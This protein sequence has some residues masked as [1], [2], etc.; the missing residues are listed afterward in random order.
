MVE[1]R[2]VLRHLGH[3][4]GKQFRIGEV[5][6]RNHRVEFVGRLAGVGVDPRLA[7]DVHFALQRVEGVLEVCDPAPAPARV[8]QR[9]HAV[10]ATVEQIELVRDLVHHDL[11]ARFR[12]LGSLDAVFQR[13]DHRPLFPAFARQF[14]IPLVQHAAVFVQMLAPH[15]KAARIHDHLVPAAQPLVAQIPH[16]R[17]AQHG[18]QQAV[19]VG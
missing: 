17:T 10:E 12:R 8:G 15:A 11:I 18:D 1:P 6:F 3:R 9:R 13:Q 7:P 5:V 4:L 14:V 2:Q 19:A 16:R